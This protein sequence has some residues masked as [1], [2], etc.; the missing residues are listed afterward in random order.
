MIF[1]PFLHF[2]CF[3]ACLFLVVFILYKNPGSSLNRSASVL[4]ICFALWNFGDIVIQNPDRTIT[5]NMVAIMQNIASIGWLGFASAIL[6]FSLAFSKREK[7]LRKKWF[8]FFVIILPLFFVYK[9]WTNCL[10]INP[11]R[12]SYGWSHEWTDTVWTYL[13]YIYYFLLSILSLYFIY[14]YG[15]KTK[16]IFEKKQAKII[17]ITVLASLIIGTI[18]DVIIPQFG[19]YGIPT[20]GNLFVF[21]FAIGL[22]YAIIKYRFLTITPTI[23][24]EKIISSM[25]E[26]LLLLDQEGNI[27]TVNEATLNSLQY[28][29]KE[30][31]G[32]PITMIFPE[33]NCTKEMLEKITKEEII[34]NHDSNFQTKNGEIIP[35]I[36]SSSLLKN[37]EG[38]IIGV[39]FVARDITEYKLTEDMLKL[40]R[41]QLANALEIAHLGH[42]EYDVEKDIFTFNDQ[43]FKI[44]RTTVEQVGEYT[45]S[46][47]EYAQRFVFPDDMPMV[48]DEVRMAIE[49]TDANYNRQIEHRIIYADGSVGYISVRFFIKK[50]AYG[51]TVST[52]GVNQDITEH[53]LAEVELQKAKEK[54]EE[55]DRLKSSFLANMSHEVRTPMNGILGFAGLL[56]EP[57]LSGEKQ[58]E[59]I[60]M[61]ENSGK[62]MLSIINDI[63]DISKIESGQMKVSVSETNI[64][65]QIKYIY[66]FFIPEVESRR[67][68]LSIKTPLPVKEANIF[69][70][71]EKIYACL[72]NLVKNAI[73]FSPNGTIELGY[74][75]K[76]KYLEFYV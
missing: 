24:A 29:Q 68:Q 51:R 22:F 49:S 50:D 15:R 21:I 25:D 28:E 72:T 11:V 42:W 41:A 69:S 26:I 35:I 6:C 13:F 45:M 52:Y 59:Y 66:D 74:E 40:N 38:I 3:V 58:L 2:F 37:E 57:N 20:L 64:N 55:S 70:D 14:F 44:F 43:F 17:T 27:I 8:L 60:R 56:K 5:E 34:K 10:T 9:Q 47:A 30:L 73:K 19:I 54:A 36:F 75:K 61:I 23:A 67:M 12:Q 16:N 48:G 33:D 32:N 76:D 39:V 18:F 71:R 46:S 7:L 1:L 31:K 63:V 4:M 65:E 62:R 53:K